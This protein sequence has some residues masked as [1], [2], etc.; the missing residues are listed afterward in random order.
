MAISP[1]RAFSAVLVAQPPSSAIK[2]TA[3]ISFASDPL[4][5]MLHNLLF[6]FSGTSPFLSQAVSTEF[7]GAKRL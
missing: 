4:P 1:R 7:S 6:D 3:P 5:V 2:A